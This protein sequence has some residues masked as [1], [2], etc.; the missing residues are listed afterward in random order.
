MTEKI[1]PSENILP[2]N[3]SPAIGLEFLGKDGVGQDMYLVHLR[4]AQKPEDVIKWVDNAKLFLAKNGCIYS[5]IDFPTPNVII[6]PFVYI[7]INPNDN[8]NIKQL[9]GGE[10]E[11]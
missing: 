2:V 7:V 11:S 1:I 10:E 8:L 5:R 6:D 3:P 4:F 9:A